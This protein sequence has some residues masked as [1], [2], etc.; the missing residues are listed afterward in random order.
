MVLFSGHLEISLEDKED[1]QSQVLHLKTRM[2]N[3]LQDQ[4]AMLPQLVKIAKEIRLSLV[5]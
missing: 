3:L 2:D 5:M 4:T 1:S